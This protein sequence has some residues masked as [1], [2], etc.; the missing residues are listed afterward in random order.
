MLDEIRQAARSQGNN[1]IRLPGSAGPHGFYQRYMWDV[2]YR[3]ASPRGM[4]D[5]SIRQ[6]AGHNILQDIPNASS[7]SPLS[8]FRDLFGTHQQRCWIRAFFPRPDECINAL[9][10]F[11]LPLAYGIAWAGLSGASQVLAGCPRLSAPASFFGHPR[12]IGL[13]HYCFSSIL[14]I[15]FL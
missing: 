15:S 4:T 10:C 9:N 12:I 11:C 3:R 14:I 5:R 6:R 7:M 8:A 1:D 13:I 2:G